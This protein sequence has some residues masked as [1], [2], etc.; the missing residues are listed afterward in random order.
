[1]EDCSCC[2]LCDQRFCQNCKDLTDQVMEIKKE[3]KY[4]RVEEWSCTVPGCDFKQIITT[5]LI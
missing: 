3:E 2:D 4:Q 1:M 5:P